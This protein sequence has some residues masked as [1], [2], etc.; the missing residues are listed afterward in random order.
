M[1]LVG[2]CSGIWSERRLCEDVHLNLVYRWFCRLDL[3][4]RVPDQ[5][6]FSKN[7]HARP[8]PRK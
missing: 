4:D 6:T 2:Y 3:T 8:V 7:R 5:S 1:L